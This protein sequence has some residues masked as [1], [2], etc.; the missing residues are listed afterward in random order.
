MR[1]THAGRVARRR[2]PTSD[3][4]RRLNPG[5]RRPGRPRPR[6]RRSATTA[7]WLDDDVRPLCPFWGVAAAGNCPAAMEFA[8]DEASH[9]WELACAHPAR[10]TQP[11]KAMTSLPKPPFQFGR[12]DQDVI[13][14]AETSSLRHRP[15]NVM[16]AKG[17]PPTSL[18]AGPTLM[19]AS[20][21]HSPGRQPAHPGWFRRQPASGSTWGSVC[22]Q[23]RRCRCRQHAVLRSW[24]VR[25]RRCA[26]PL[27]AGRSRRSATTPPST[28]GPAPPP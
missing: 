10:V 4:R 20:H 1:C 6:R 13:H 12:D 2:R 27:A 25:R 19:A 15:F 28:C 11:T 9:Q 8:Y 3:G 24:R 16:A 23:S 5:R 7:A 21:C 14:S 26:R 17:P 22:R 18:F